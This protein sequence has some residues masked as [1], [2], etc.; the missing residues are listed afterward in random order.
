M[1]FVV[2]GI[3]AYVVLQLIVG[4]VVSRRIRT[5]EDYLLAGRRLGYPLATFSVFATWFGAES[6]IGAAGAAYDR[7]LKG[8]V[9]DPLGYAVCL[10]IMGAVLA[11]PLWKMRLTTIADLFRIRYSGLVEKT[12]VLL[13]VPTSLFWAA[14]QI[15]AFGLVLS[16]SSPWT[17]TFSITVAALLV[18]LYTVLGGL[19][20]DATTDV[21]QGIAIIAGLMILLPLVMAD[22]VISIA[23]VPLYRDEAESGAGWMQALESMAI[24]VCGSL[25]AQELVSRVIASKSAT[26]ARRSSVIAAFAYLIVGIIPVTMGLIGYTV[27]PGLG[28]PEQILPALARK[29]FT[30]TLYVLFAGAVVSAI[31]S[32]VDSALLAC[33]ALLSHNLILPLRPGTGE[34]Q[35]LLLNRVGVVVMGLFAYVLALHAEG[36]YH[37]VKEASSF[38][39]AGIF[40]VVM[41]GLFTS[42]GGSRS[43]WSCLLTGASV[44]V[45]AEYGYGL[46]FSYLTALAASVLIYVT[47]GLI[48]RRCGAALRA[49]R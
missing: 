17:V 38:G 14:A 19:L 23:N 18:I 24:P 34:K 36:V 27:F 32:T 12:A 13:M 22:H 42:F 44:W 37:L 7:G 5:E 3:L 25:V 26:V 11:V 31:L 2:L 40:V 47:V 28:D 35:K 16:A 20:A 1:D 43:A 49:G 39:S 15:R 45:V 8:I 33:S 29:Y 10:L 9:S 30:S 48:D 41:F 4:A 46:S 6:C 21:I